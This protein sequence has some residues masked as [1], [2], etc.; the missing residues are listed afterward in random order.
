[1]MRVSK[2]YLSILLAFCFL[3]SV[4]AVYPQTRAT[5][6]QKKTTQQ[7][8]APQTAVSLND[9]CKP[10]TPPVPVV[11]AIE[12]IPAVLPGESTVPPARAKIAPTATSQSGVTAVNN[13]SAAAPCVPGEKAAPAVPPV[14][15]Q[16]AA[17]AMEAV[18]AVPAKPC[19]TGPEYCWERKQK[20]KVP[21]K[22]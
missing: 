21:N 20:G 10:D 17:P 7:V 14:P 18:P 2:A 11:P 12:A 19:D 6:S 3:T 15:A 4:N 13:K 16:E 8:Q 9:D 1:M 22:P 5:R